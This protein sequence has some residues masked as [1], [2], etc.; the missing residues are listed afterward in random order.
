MITGTAAIIGAIIVNLAPVA[1]TVD[2][3]SL[4]WG[5][6]W[7]VISMLAGCFA[8]QCA[9]AFVQGIAVSD[10]MYAALQSEPYEH[11]LEAPPDNLQDEIASGYLFPLTYLTKSSFKKGAADPLT[12]EKRMMKILCIT[13]LLTWAQSGTAA[14]GLIVLA[15]GMK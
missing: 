15:V 4:K 8:K 3:R 13:I 11:N 1:A 9:E 7:L 12:G 10:E 5:I 14:A 6:I 2:A